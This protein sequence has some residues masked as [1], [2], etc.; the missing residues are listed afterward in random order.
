MNEHI[1]T[2]CKEYIEN[3]NSP[4]FAIF[5]K[6]EW[7]CGKTYFINKIIEEYQDNTNPTSKKKKGEPDNGIRK[8][9][10]M[11]IS[12]FGVSQTSEIDDLI[13]QKL[14]P[15][16][17][18]KQFRFSVNV[19]RVILK[20]QLNLEIDQNEK[21]ASVNL[22]TL[23]IKKLIIVDD[24]ER[25]CLTPSQIF[26]YFSEYLY[27]LGMKI[28]FIGNE[29]YI[30]QRDEY[31]KIKEKTI[32]LEFLISPEREAAID[33]FIN[34]LS[35]TNKKFNYIKQLCMDA[36]M[37][38]KCNNL[39]TVRQCL[40]NLKILFNSLDEN[41][42]LNHG[43]DIAK[44]FINLFIQK[45]LNHINNKN[46]IREAIIGYEKYNINFKEYS[47]KKDKNDLLFDSLN[48]Y[49]PLSNCWEEIIFDGNYAKEKLLEEYK[50]ENTV[51]TKDQ[52][53]NLFLLMQ[54]WREMDN[55]NFENIINNVDKEFQGGVYLHPGEIL[56][57]F[58]IMLFFSKWELI[59]RNNEEIQIMVKNTI[60]NYKDKIIPIA[61]WGTLEM[62]YAGWGYS[63][64]VPEIKEMNSLLKE[65]SD[66]NRCVYAK[67][68]I[69]EEVLNIKKN[70]HEFCRNI[71]NVNGT[72]KY[73]RIPI[74]SLIDVKSF[75]YIFNDLDVAYQERIVSSFEERYGKNNSHILIYKEYQLDRNNLKE[76]T[77][78]YDASLGK[79]LYSPKELFKKDI[80]KRLHELLEYFDKQ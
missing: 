53:K 38:L 28:I 20:S 40:F 65:I 22:N 8:K 45:C 2:Y 73:Y 24:I 27:Q 44:I 66:K 48:K 6:G 56:H 37:S 3:E 23:E 39:R 17:S 42:I 18:S 80:S 70:V 79:T 5:L 29:D 19:L 36:M 21:S 16:L 72:N 74:F 26:G 35:L 25:C 9:E 30:T 77:E 11:Y 32:G 31:Q 62:G 76:F 12:L 59:P 47:E 67:E 71:L 46:E 33:N 13:F 61:D 64:G 1:K 10:I 69:D 34:E 68:S 78:L 49:I 54:T 75:F 14:H 50:K 7:G 55:K 60:N 57:Y 58:N 51:N 63:D 43:V 41:V 4:Q 15:V 52:P